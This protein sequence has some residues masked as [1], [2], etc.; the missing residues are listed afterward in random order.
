MTFCESKRLTTGKV[1]IED[2]SHILE[3]MPQYQKELNKY[4]MH[5]NV[6]E[7]CMK[8]LRALWRNCTNLAMGS[9]AEGEKIKDAMKLIM[10]VPLDAAVP[11]YDKIRVLLLCILLRNGSRQQ[12]PGVSEENLLKLIQ[13]AS[14]QAHSGLIWDLE[15]LGGTVTSPGYAGSRLWGQRLGIGQ[16]A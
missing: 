5:L 10:P 2:L 3:K 4:S 1:N 12:P 14:V 8:R 13:H 9:D 6:A 7:D 11:A 15:W 16:M